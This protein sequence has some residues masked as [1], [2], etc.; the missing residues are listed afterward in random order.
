MTRK[1]RERGNGQGTV[2]PRRNKAGKVIGYVGAFFGPDGKRHWVSA[3]TKTE[4]WRK[5][6]MAM[7]GCEAQAANLISS[8]TYQPEQYDEAFEEMRLMAARL[9]EEDRVLL[10][11]LVHAARAAASSID[12]DDMTPVGHKVRWGWHLRHYYEMVSNMVEDVPEG[13]RKSA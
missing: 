7:A 6:N 8:H 12:P 10:A 4:C 9:T 5:L 3:K 2:A 13:V 11:E 1:K